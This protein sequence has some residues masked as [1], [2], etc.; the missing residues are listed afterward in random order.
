ME[1]GLSSCEAK[2]ERNGKGLTDDEIFLVVIEVSSFDSSE[3]LLLGRSIL[4]VDDV[5]VVVEESL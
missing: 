4:P 3:K 5:G 2:R 1:V